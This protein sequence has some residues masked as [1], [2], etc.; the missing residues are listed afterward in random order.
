MCIKCIPDFKGF[1]AQ[2][3]SH[4]DEWQKPIQYRKAIVLQ[5]KINKSVKKREMG[6]SLHQPY[7]IL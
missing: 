2:L 6:L 3:L 1:V 5:V 7:E 4:I